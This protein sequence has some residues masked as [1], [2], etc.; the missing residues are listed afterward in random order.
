[1]L[2]PRPS[3]E[4]HARP[5]PATCSLRCWL[6][7]PLQLLRKHSLRQLHLGYNALASLPAAL[8]QLTQLRTL[9]LAHN[10]LVRLPPEVGRLQRLERLELQ[11][12][13]LQGVPVELA[14]CVGGRGGAVQAAGE[15]ART[16][17]GSPW[18]LCPL[19]PLRPS[20]SHTHPSCRPGMLPPLA[21][22]CTCS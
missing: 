12:N 13:R 11:G 22:W 19:C 2:S 5:A 17:R 1:M 10:C 18:P 4:R 14:R 20:A 8:G 7:A 15:D 21:G 3:I 16:C 9:A 6:P